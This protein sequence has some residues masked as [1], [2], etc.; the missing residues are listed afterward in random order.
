MSALQ[1]QYWTY[2]K[3]YTE[4]KEQFFY[5]DIQAWQAANNC[6]LNLKPADLADIK[7]ELKCLL[8]ADIKK[9]HQK[10]VEICHPR[11]YV[12]AVCKKDL[13]DILRKAANDRKNRANFEHE[14]KAKMLDAKNRK[15]ESLLA[16]LDKYSYEE[17]RELFVSALNIREI[18]VIHLVHCDFDY[19]KIAQTLKI[20][21]DYCRKIY[22]Q[23]ENKLTAALG[24]E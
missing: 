12:L 23:A 7:S 22:N 24:L 2:Y 14:W 8:L 9:N 15:N 13:F 5:K 11:N 18:T 17:I 4:Y 21:V 1:N 3:F 10:N 19:V 6:Y 20:S 16:T